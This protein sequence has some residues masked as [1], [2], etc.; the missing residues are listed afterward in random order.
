MTDPASRKYSENKS[1]SLNFGSI[2]AIRNNGW[3]LVWPAELTNQGWS[4]FLHKKLSNNGVDA[5]LRNRRAVWLSEHV[6]N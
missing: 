4:L 2:L 6:D 1:S 5:G 3:S